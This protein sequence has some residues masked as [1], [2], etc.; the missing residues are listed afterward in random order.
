MMKTKEQ[1]LAD[2]LADP[3]YSTMI[4]MVNGEPVA[5]S[6]DERLRTLNEW[7]DA[8]FEQQVKKWLNVEDFMAEFT[9]PEK[10]QI[11]L[12]EDPTIATLRFELTTWL[13]AVHADDP[14]VVM[15]LSKLVELGIISEQRKT[16]ITSTP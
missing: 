2:L 11:A 9:M 10:A 3:R 14:R 5:M 1:I 15:G 8:E 7:V 16:E 6:D 12:S 4:K 13:S